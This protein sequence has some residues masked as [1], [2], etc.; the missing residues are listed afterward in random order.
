TAKAIARLGKAYG[1]IAFYDRA[2]EKLEQ[3]AKKYAGEKDAYDAMNDAVFY[4]KGIG[5]DDKAITDTKYFVDTFGKKKPAEAAA[6]AFS[7]VSIYEK[8]GD[9]DGVIKHL[10]DYI[11]VWGAKGGEDKLVIAHAKIGNL[12]WHQSCPVKEIDGACVKITR[13]R[14]VVTKES[15]VK[16][17][18]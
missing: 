1:D 2:A 4:Q 18:K 5:N 17:K 3:Y 11:H 6:A 10:Q 8:R 14:A 13:E 15:K 7:L 12:L 16:K 9:N